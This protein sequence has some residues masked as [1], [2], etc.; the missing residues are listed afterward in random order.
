MLH[1]SA[2]RLALLIIVGAGLIWASAAQAQYV[3]SNNND[4]GAGSLRQA[5][6]DADN[7]GAPL[8]VPNGTTP[9]IVFNAGVGT[10]TLASA[11]PLIYSNV[12]ITGSAGAAIDGAGSFRGL[13]VSG[14]AT[15][16]NGAPASV[17]VSISNLAIQNVVAQGGNGGT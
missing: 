17:T 3:V 14:L 10:I 11:L 2:R 13:F 16:G 15:T 6:I 12:T 1:A 9:A 4:S 8:G 5:I 7:A